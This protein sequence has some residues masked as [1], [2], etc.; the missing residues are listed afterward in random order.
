MTKHDP[1]REAAERLAGYVTTC[2]MRNSLPWMEG[3]CVYLNEY[4]RAAQN[5]D[6][7]QTDG[8]GLL[9]ERETRKP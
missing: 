5:S 2:Q 4:H 9:V 8:Y 7:V 1:V 6:R 3:L